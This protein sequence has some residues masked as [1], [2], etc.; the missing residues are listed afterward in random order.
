MIK[1]LEHPKDNH[2][3][4]SCDTKIEGK[5]KFIEYI[6]LFMRYACICDA[7]HE[8]YEEGEY[9][10]VI[11]KYEEYL[12][13]KVNSFEYVKEYYKFHPDKFNEWLDKFSEKAK[14]VIK[15]WFK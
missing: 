6:P 4:Y 8:K 5:A 15:G 7:C 9:V 2:E 13:G 10:E 11:K 14:K 1:S 3:C 12:A